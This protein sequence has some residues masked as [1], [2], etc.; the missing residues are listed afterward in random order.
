MKYI[1]T[2]LFLLFA[3]SLPAQNSKP[4]SEK[5]KMSWGVTASFDINIPTTDTSRDDFRH[6]DVPIEYGGSAG[7]VLRFSWPRGWFIEP[8]A[9]IGYDYTSL[10]PADIDHPRVG[11]GQWRIAV[12]VTGGY[13]FEI[14]NNFGIGPV[15]GVE[16]ICNFASCTHGLP[17]ECHYTSS[18]LWRPLN[19]AVKAGLQIDMDNWAVTTQA[20]I[21]LFP[22]EKHDY[23]VIYRSAPIT[24]QVTV[25]AKYY[26]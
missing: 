26:F 23:G 16:L 1:I 12:P 24:A 15:A 18:Q 2:G 3:L 25:T 17:A 6:D 20:H 14:D 8:G 5:A 22:I 11:V 19:F 21:G 10:D 9:R 13:I 7:A 4:E